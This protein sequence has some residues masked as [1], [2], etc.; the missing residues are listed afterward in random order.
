MLQDFSDGIL[1]TYVQQ[2]K[3]FNTSR[4]PSAVAELRVG[5]AVYYAILLF[6]NGVSTAA[7]LSQP[8]CQMVFGVHQTTVH[9]HSIIIFMRCI[10]LSTGI[11]LLSVSE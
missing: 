9:I 10:Q 7:L 3:D 8:C 1:S 4:G 2:L 5:T 11:A 6:S